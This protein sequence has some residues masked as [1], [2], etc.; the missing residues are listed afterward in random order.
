MTDWVLEGIW[1]PMEE[2][3]IGSGD[4]RETE[5]DAVQ[6]RSYNEIDEEENDF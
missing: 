2:E 1:K 5:K 6:R 3:L 4:T